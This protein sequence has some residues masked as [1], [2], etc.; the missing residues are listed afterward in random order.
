MHAIEKLLAGIP[1][2]LPAAIALIQ[3]RSLDHADYLPD[4][5]RRW[6]P[7]PVRVA[8]DGEPIEAGHIYL[9]RPD[10]HLTVTRAHRFLYRDGARIRFVRSSAN[11][12]SS[13]PRE[14]S[15]RRSLAL[16]SPGT[17]ATR[18]TEFRA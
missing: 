11:P 3:H 8:I 17:D 9:A 16:S 5:V 7:W 14:P 18:L 15:A 12:L 10:S 2:T 1:P 6:T 4:L 13:Q